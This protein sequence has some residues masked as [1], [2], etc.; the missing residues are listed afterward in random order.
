MHFVFRFT[1]CFG[2]RSQGLSITDTIQI[3][4]EIYYLQEVNYGVASFFLQVPEIQS[5]NP[6]ESRKCLKTLVAREYHF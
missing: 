4:T 6:R 3:T 2:V 1:S 5:C